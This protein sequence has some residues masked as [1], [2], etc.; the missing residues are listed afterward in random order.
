MKILG[1][2]A[3]LSATGICLLDLDSFN[4]KTF[5]RD[6]LRSDLKDMERILY[7]EKR[8]MD[9]A[10][11]VD[12]VVI[13][14]YAFDAK[15]NRE[16][17]GEL[18]GVIKRRLYLMNK[19]ILLLDTHKCKEVLTGV[20]RNPTNLKTKE[21]I[22]SYTKDRFNIDF[23]GEDN[24]CDAF[25]LALIGLSYLDNNIINKLNVS[26]DVRYSINKII[27]KIEEQKKPKIKKNL[28][29][30][31]SLPFGVKCI[32]EKDIYKLYIKDLEVFAEGI[33]LKKA[34]VALEKEKRLKIRE[35]RKNKK[36]IKFTKSKANTF[37]FV[38]KH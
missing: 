29:Y 11:N 36:R 4:N 26:D 18:Q 32:L 33:T 20:S 30:Y 34:L 13:E 7:I 23:N 10:K 28:S 35:L 9:Y 37:S 19:P 15:Y 25:G 16:T 21:W 3:S 38:I 27:K 17:L 22:M 14:N 6:T 8:I 12:L 31:F 5:L 24:E 1:I 2:D